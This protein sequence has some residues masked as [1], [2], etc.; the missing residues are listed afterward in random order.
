MSTT[1]NNLTADLT[2]GVKDTARDAKEAAQAKIQDIKQHLHSGTEAWQDKADETT[3][4]AK[5][6]TDQA[7]A[8]LPP[9]LV[10]RANQL[11]AAVRRRPVPAVA[12]LLGALL[13]LRRLLRRTS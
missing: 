5:D 11:M 1:T 2:T 13:V 7:V 12:V 9:P 3:Q 4:Q 8:R 6:L 10:G